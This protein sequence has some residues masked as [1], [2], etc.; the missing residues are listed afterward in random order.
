MAIKEYV[1]VKSQIIDRRNSGKSYYIAECDE[2][3][4]EFYPTRSNSKYCSNR[5]SQKAYHKRI[6]I[7]GNKPIKK[8]ERKTPENITVKGWNN[9]Y[10]FLKK[11]Y[12]TKGKKAE[13][14]A[15]LKGL[16]IGAAFTYEKH[17]VI[18][19]APYG[20]TIQQYT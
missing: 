10:L 20:F 6:A 5:C 19:F 8:V 15:A 13:I 1:R 3:A 17:K 4:T 11:T 9:V 16:S 12:K 2:C 14:I 18:R 7:E